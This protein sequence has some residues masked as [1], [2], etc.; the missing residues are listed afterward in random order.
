MTITHQITEI[1]TGAVAEAQ[2]QGVLP[3]GD[4]PTAPVERPQNPEHGDFAYSLPLR[5]A[6]V[7]RKAPLQIA[8]S[9]AP[10]V[11]TNGVIGSVASRH[12]SFMGATLPHLM[13]PI[14]R[15]LAEI[16]RADAVDGIVLCPV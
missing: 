5:L 4:L 12:F 11:P 6:K 2:R 16:L 3:A 14:A 15:D 7:A 13:E 1:L 8:E 10:F 9:L